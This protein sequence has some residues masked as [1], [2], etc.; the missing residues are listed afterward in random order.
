MP[1]AFAKTDYNESG[2]INNFY[3]AG[4]GIFNSALDTDTIQ[5]E[6]LT[7]G[8]LIPLVADLDSDGIN[9][10]VVFSLNFKNQCL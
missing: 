1:F 4:T 5:T 3:Q 10:I 9:E 6:V 8:K 7:D 2:H